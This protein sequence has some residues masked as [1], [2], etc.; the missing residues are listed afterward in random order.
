MKFEKVSYKEF[1][2]HTDSAMHCG[3]DEYDGIVM[4]ARSTAGSA[5]YDIC[6]PVDI[7]I[8]GGCKRVIPSGLKV[9]LDEGWCMQ[10]FIRS[11]LAIKKQLEL[12]TSVSIIDSDYYDNPSNEG[13]IM[14]PVRN[15]SSRPILITAGE[16][17]AQ[18]VFVIYGKTVDD[19]A[20]GQRSGGIGSTDE[21]R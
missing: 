3:A 7:T 10:M 14:I 9:Q 13:H 8:P 5:G 2:K 16:R 21:K 12:Q 4:P 17:I 19:A 1:K 18:G 11:S 20:E 15:E 6:S